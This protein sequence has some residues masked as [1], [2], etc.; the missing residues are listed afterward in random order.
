[1]IAIYL[2]AGAILLL[3]AFE[4]LFPAIAARLGLAWERRRAGLVLR[5]AS[6]PRFGMPY[7]EGGS[8]APIVLVHGFGGDKDNF[9]RIARFL[10]GAFHVLIPDLPGFGDA[11]RA[12]DASYRIADQVEH[13][14]AFLQQLGIARAHLGGNSMGGF[15]VAEYAARYPAQ[16]ASLWLLDAAGTAAAYDNELIG[17][18]RA[19]GEMPLLLRSAGQ[20][21]AMLRACTCRPLFVPYCIKWQLGKRAAADYASHRRIMEQVHDSPLLES[22]F[23]T[24]RVPALIVWGC[25]DKILSPAGAAA[26]KAILPDSRVIM[27]PGVG[28]LPMLE[29]P[30]KCAQDYLAF[31]RTLPVARAP[32]GTDS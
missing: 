17:N 27:M 20:V 11:S 1:M 19:S 14:H 22:Q 32:A 9:T 6:I 5:Q 12:A 13:L 25:E 26:L 30:R 15:I 4:R 10:T 21:G 16:V 18:Y 29:A 7:L 3:A 24:I 23:D 31:L 2:L 28:H 8:G